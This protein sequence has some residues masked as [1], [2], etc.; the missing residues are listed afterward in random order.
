MY[1]MDIPKVT[2][3]RVDRTRLIRRIVR[4]LNHS[5]VWTDIIAMKML[6][7]PAPIV[8]SSLLEVDRPARLNITE[9]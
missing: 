7:Q 3:N 9:E 2:R 8:A 6:Q 4:L 1:P 5:I